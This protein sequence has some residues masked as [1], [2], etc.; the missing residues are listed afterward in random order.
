MA[1]LALNGGNPVRTKEFPGWPIFD[2]SEIRALEEVVRSGK[3]FAP[4]GTK[5][6]EFEQRFAGFQDAKYGIAVC[7]GTIALEMALLALGVGAGDEVIIPAYTFVA[8]ATAVLRCNAIPIPVDIDPDTY[9]ID[10]EAV[11]KAV[12]DKTRAIIPVHLSGLPVD[13][14]RINDI[15]EK[16]GLKVVEDAA[17]AW[18]A[19]WKGKGVG[20]LGNLGGFS[21]QM[22]KNL[23]AGEG[24]MILT[25]DKELADLCRA[26][27]DCGRLPGKPRYDCHILGVNA[28]LTEFQGAVL[29]AQ[30]DRYPDLLA[31][32]EA[33]AQAL[34]AMLEEQ[35]QL[36]PIQRPREATGHAYHFMMLKY[37]A[38]KFDGIPKSRFLEALNAEGITSVHGGY[39]KTVYEHPVLA[40]RKVGARGCPLSCPFY[41]KEIDYTKIHCPV[42]EKAIRE[43]AI[44]VKQNVLLAGPE[45][46]GDIVEAVGKIHEHRAELLK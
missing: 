35:G 36:T 45:E 16:H 37:D 31:R 25:N 34:A 12:T 10:P 22:S 44:W 13:M 15:A 24:G 9:L 28:R 38:E 39:G 29:H 19:G 8:T 6:K 26:V 23:T 43:E 21:F 17:Q 5:V 1:S 2:E 42:A 40:D 46:M 41:G 18:G 11:R 3:W 33:S 4:G 7:N 32:R 27:A 30:L 20:A 14:D